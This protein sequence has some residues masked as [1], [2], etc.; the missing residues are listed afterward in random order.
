MEQ[1]SED[2]LKKL[3]ERIQY[4]ELVAEK[5]GMTK[6]AKLAL[7][8]ES[9][10]KD[11]Q[12][13]AQDFII[14]MNSYFSAYRSLSTGLVQ[15]V[16][17]ESAFETLK[18]WAFKILGFVPIIGDYIGIIDDIISSI[19]DNWKEKKIQERTE[20][21]MEIVKALMVWDEDEIS[22]AVGWTAVQLCIWYDSRLYGV[23]AKKAVALILGY[24]I[25]FGGPYNNFRENIDMTSHTYTGFSLSCINKLWTAKKFG[26]ITL[27]I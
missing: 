17:D 27:N 5:S 19:I 16:K 3:E 1:S 24:L 12:Q 10:D 15:S 6:K 9:L 25:M 2:K 4:L 11:L 26:K 21:V 8:F 23:D 14:T 7:A 13:F 18:T 22:N 20:K